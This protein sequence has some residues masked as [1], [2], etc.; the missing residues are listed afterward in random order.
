MV[1]RLIFSAVLLLACGVTLTA[2]ARSVVRFGEDITVAD[3]QEAE[4]DFYGIGSVANI[5]GTVAG[6][7]HVV[8]GRVSIRGSVASDTLAIGV[9]TTVDGEVGDDLRVIGDDVTIAGH[10]HGD[11]LVIARTLTI[12]KEAKVDGDVIF[13]GQNGTISGEIGNDVFGRVTA[14][15]LDGKVA[16]A[17]EVSVGDLTLGD[18]ASIAGT[19]QYESDEEIVRAP[20]ATVAGEIIRQDPPAVPQTTAMRGIFSIFATLIFATGVWYL[21]LRRSLEVIGSRSVQRPLRAGLIGLSVLFSVPFL[22]GALFLS[23]LGIF[24]GVL[25]LVFYIFSLGVSAIA[26]VAVVGESIR[27]W[28]APKMAFGVWWLL[29]GALVLTSLLALPPLFLVIPLAALLIA[30]GAF[31]E[32]LYQQ[33][34]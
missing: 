20:N 14:L 5:S 27:T 31:C 2:E 33:V 11:L 10:V 8:A 25:L 30:L 4:G 17:V 15:R 21:L 13:F 22:V 28:V 29:A 6:D 18:K 26:A 34:R 7:A 24:A 16:G 1:N 19:I 9:V 12:L 32:Y 3:K 23:Q